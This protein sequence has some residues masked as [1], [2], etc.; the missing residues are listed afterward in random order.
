MRP[1]ILTG[2]EYL[3]LP[4]D[5]ETWLLRP[6]IPQG[7]AAALYGDPKLGKSYLAVQL[8]LALT[9]AQPSWLGFH[10]STVG[11]VVYLQLDTPGSLWSQRLKDLRRAGLPIDRIHF[12]DRETLEHY[13]FDILQPAHLAYIKTLV[14]EIQPTT[15][16]VDT[17]RE[18]H[19]G[20]EDS[21]T[22][23]RNVISNLVAATQP[24]A[25]IIIS[26]ARKPSQ[27]R[28]GDL[29][30]D[31]RGS[32]YVVGRMDAVIRLTKKALHY[33]GR[34]IEEGQIKLERQENGLWLP[35]M[36]ES[37]AHLAQVVANTALTTL[38]AKAR[39]LSPLINKSEDAAL[40]AIRRY[41]EAQRGS[42][43]VPTPA[44]QPVVTLDPEIWIDADRDD[45]PFEINGV[46][47]EEGKKSS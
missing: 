13:P 12:A 8:A 29:M 7:G 36:D 35:V 16:I 21:S 20:D 34:A 30:A 3:A 1:G 26:H 37:T 42:G 6:L 47:D 44:P 43:I 11:R 19:S 40:S 2:A 32:G 41:I 31:Q 33:T 46:S 9:G 15:V 38:R 10:V 22:V 45:K 14:R 24:A 18:S 5:R 39:V 23:M 27:D 4:R 28:P 25:L 17:V